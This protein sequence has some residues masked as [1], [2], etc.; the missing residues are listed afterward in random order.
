VVFTGTTN[1]QVNFVTSFSSAA[2]DTQTTTVTLPNGATTATTRFYKIDLSGNQ[3]TLSID[4][5]VLATHSLHIPG[6][7]DN[8]SI[9]AGTLN[10]AAVT[11]TTLSVDLIYFYN[12]N[13][14]QIDSDYQGEPLIVGAQ[15]D[16]V[17]TGS[18][19]ATAQNLVFTTPSARSTYSFQIAGTWTGVINFEKSNDGT[20]WVT[21]AV[22]DG[23]SSNTLNSVTANGIFY[24]SA[25]AKPF[26]RLRSSGTWTGTATAT[27]IK[28]CGTSGIT[29]IDSLPTGTNTIGR[30][31]SKSAPQYGTANQALTITLASL[32]NNA[33]R[34]STFV[35]NTTNLFDDALIF[36]KVTSANSGTSA[37]GYVNVYGYATVDGGTTYSENVTGTDA[38]IT[39]VNPTNLMLL[40]QINVVANNVTY[41]AGPFSFCRMY[42]LDQLP[43]RWGVVVTNASGATLNATGSNHGITWQGI[44]RQLI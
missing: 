39:L 7:Y 14:V 19:T 11:A 6:P 30:I 41:R 40:A 12:N 32:S 34:A 21:M 26:V 38:A 15:A 3:A 43:A 28:S 36:I 9:T 25:G 10:S 4:G 44:N 13:R 31:L 29:V 2:A 33:S 23:A 8:M 20:N 42:G 22:Y 17:A 35:D 27:L 1:T 16:D 18:I 5:V 37:T 24:T